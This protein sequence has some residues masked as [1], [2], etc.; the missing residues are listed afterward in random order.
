METITYNLIFIQKEVYT[1]REANKALNKRRRTKKTR[2]R[3]KGLLIISN[4]INLI[5]SKNVNT[6]LQRDLRRNNKG[7]G[8]GREGP[9]RCG[10]YYNVNYNSRTY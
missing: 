8:R 2:L 6:Q 5:D 10:R 1:L 9:K 3:D 7:D 4:T